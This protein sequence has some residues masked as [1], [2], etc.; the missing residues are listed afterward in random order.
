MEPEVFMA[1]KKLLKFVKISIIY[2]YI[3]RFSAEIC[4]RVKKLKRKCTQ[5]FA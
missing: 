1:N 4:G 5:I 3:R 2:Y